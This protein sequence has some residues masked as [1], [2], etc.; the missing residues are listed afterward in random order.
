MCSKQSSKINSIV[1]DYLILDPT[2]K[3][4]KEFEILKTLVDAY[5]NKDL[6]KFNK[7]VT[8]NNEITFIGSWETYLLFKIKDDLEK[9]LHK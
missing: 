4:S 3:N 2:F 9:N 7:A 6:E 5:K 1:S 8:Q